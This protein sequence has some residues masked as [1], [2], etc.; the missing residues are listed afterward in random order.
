MSD[1]SILP[2]LTDQGKHNALRTMYNKLSRAT[3]LRMMD[4]YKLDQAVH[5]R[6]AALSKNS[7]SLYKLYMLAEQQGVFDQLIAH[8]RA[9]A[10]EEA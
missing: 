1:A 7:I 10:E 2:A 6:R 4:I 8:Q 9:R 3:E 5:D